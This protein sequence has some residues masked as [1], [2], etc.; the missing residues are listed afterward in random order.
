MRAIVRQV[1][2]LHVSQKQKHAHQDHI[3]IITILYLRWKQNITTFQKTSEDEV[4]GT[5]FVSVIVKMS[6]WSGGTLK[7]Y[8]VGYI[9]LFISIKKICESK[10]LFEAVFRCEKE[11]WYNHFEQ[12]IFVFNIRILNCGKKILIYLSIYMKRCAWK[13]GLFNGFVVREKSKFEEK[14]YLQ[15]IIFDWL[16][17]NQKIFISF[18]Y[19]L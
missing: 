3:I 7:I 1:L 12:I 18:I 19:F 9:L 8:L 10:C 15:I 4:C 11:L 13:I 14:F 17:L 16:L 2:L 6:I 5:L